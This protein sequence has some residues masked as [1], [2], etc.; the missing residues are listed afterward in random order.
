MFSAVQIFGKYSA[1][2]QQSV[3]KTDQKPIVQ[4]LFAAIQNFSRAEIVDVGSLICGI[5]HAKNVWRTTERWE[6]DACVSSCFVLRV[7]K[8]REARF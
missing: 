3:R 4:K 6:E 8:M 1:E 7:G 5:L 2:N